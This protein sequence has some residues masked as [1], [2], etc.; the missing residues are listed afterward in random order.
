MP[1]NKL[2]DLPDNI[3]QLPKAAQMKWMATFNSVFDKEKD[4]G[5][6]MAAANAAIKDMKTRDQDYSVW[7]SMKARCNN[8]NDKDYARYGGRGLSVC[9]RWRDSFDDFMKDMGHRKPGY[10][11][12][13]INN[14]GNYEPKNCKWVDRNTQAQNRNYA[15]MYDFEAEIFS[16]GNWNGDEY[17]EKDLHG[18]A[19]AFE[20]LKEEIK[21]MLKLGN[22]ENKFDP[23]LGWVEGLR[24]QGE[25][26]YAKFMNVPKI[27]YDAIKN[28]LYKRVSV[29][30]FPNYK[31]KS[32]GNL[33][34]YVLDGV[35]ILGAAVPAVTNLADLTKYMTSKFRG[36]TDDDHRI[37]FEIDNVFKHELKNKERGGVMPMTDEEK[38]QFDDLQRENKTLKLKNETMENQE[39][40]R[41]KKEFED[42]KKD[43]KEFC[44][45]AVKDKTMLPANRDL[46][47]SSLEKE[48]P[49][50][51]MLMEL[52][53]NQVKYFENLDGEKGLRENKQDKFDDPGKELDL[54]VKKYRVDHPNATYEGAV[55]I[56]LAEDTDLA[57]RYTRRAETVSK[58]D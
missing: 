45:K 19:Q 48:N 21:P 56:L 50:L 8:P 44:E 25:K 15:K 38:K 17:T 55:E 32:N 51:D 9:Q 39:Q 3:K 23:A 22:H 49:D 35:A 46:I 18:I 43:V 27:L 12:E 28:R 30:L 37:V 10:T 31:G 24:V 7:T 47:F 53:G 14:D 26:L 41:K 11:I 42:K 40:D 33:Y 16:T 36:G 1:Y 54:K 57:K 4:E 5:K 6:A 2:S 20:A 58:R 13:R 52:A 29:E 34:P